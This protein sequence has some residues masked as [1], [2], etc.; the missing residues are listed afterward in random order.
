MF[1]VSTPPKI[2]RTFELKGVVGNEP[3]PGSFSDESSACVRIV[4]HVLLSLETWNNQFL[5]ADLKHGEQNERIAK[6]GR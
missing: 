3:Y 5:N 4:S 6:E 2:E 1:E